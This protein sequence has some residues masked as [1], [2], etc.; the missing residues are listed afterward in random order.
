[1]VD[2]KVV[3]DLEDEVE[4]PEDEV[5]TPEDEVET[6][7]DDVETGTNIC[8]GCFISLKCLNI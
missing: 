2:G 4:T 5:E 3:E 8:C 1:M 6:P 7:E